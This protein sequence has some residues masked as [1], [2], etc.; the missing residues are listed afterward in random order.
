MKILVIEAKNGRYRISVFPGSLG[1]FLEYRN[2]R[3]NIIDKSWYVYAFSFNEGN[4]FIELNDK[5][6]KRK[7]L[8]IFNGFC[9]HA[10]DV[11]SKNLNLNYESVS[12]YSFIVDIGIDKIYWDKPTNREL[13]LIMKARLLNNYN[14]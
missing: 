5:F 11:I 4:K 8:D 12:E 1:C 10:F 7:R 2:K 9:F 14:L 13:R 6:Y 3:I